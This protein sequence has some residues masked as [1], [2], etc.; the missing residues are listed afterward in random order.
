MSNET[1][2]V[3]AIVVVAVVVVAAMWMFSRRRKT[4]AL[5][6]R[7]GPEYDHVL[8][9]TRTPAEAERE[10]LTRQSRVEK[11][12]IRPL[13]RE[14]A[15]RFSAAWRSVQAQFVDDP[16]KAVIEADRLIADVMRSRGY[17][18][19]D[20]NRVIDD[21]SVDHAHVI[22]HYRA[23][24]EIVA[25]HEKGQASTEDLRQAMVHFRAL[26]DELV[27]VNHTDARRAS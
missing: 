22:N 6:A 7:F 17:P 9:S 1:L 12:S 2:M 20:P 23:G 21:L 13:S 16:R 3:V 11:F 25:R 26:F 24:R 4:A 18:L 27:G 5:R 19:D 10:L 15:D 14:D 8:H